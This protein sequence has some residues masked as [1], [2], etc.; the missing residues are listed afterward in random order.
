MTNAEQLF[1]NYPDNK[2][3]K[4]TD[5]LRADIDIANYNNLI[6]GLILPKNIS[7]A[8]EISQKELTTLFCEIKNPD[9]I[10]AISHEDYEP[11]EDDTQAIQEELIVE[12]HYIEKN[13]FWM[14]KAARWDIR[15][16]KAIPQ[17]GIALW[18]NTAT[19][20]G[21]KLR[22][23]SWLG[24]SPLDEIEKTNTKLKSSFNHISQY[25]V[26]N[27]VL[28]T[29][30]N[31]VSDINFNNP[32]YNNLKSKGIYGY[33][34]EYFLNQ[35]AFDEEKQGGQCYTPKKYHCSDCQNAATIQRSCTYLY[36]GFRTK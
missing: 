13:I 26:G 11:N 18:V 25:R 30:I 31:A 2:F 34:Y 28:T 27:K 10:C 19:E 7:N 22:S 33:V 4:T 3:W 36:N 9:E 15:K 35:F 32:E 29:L 8:F 16:N 12:D 14:P 24:N 6:F 20:Q 21:V 17:I 23:A 5:K 1:I